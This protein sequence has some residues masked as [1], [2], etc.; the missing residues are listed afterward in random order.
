MKLFLARHG[1][2][3]ADTENPRRP[4]SPRGR[5]MTLQVAAFLRRSGALAAVHSV[6]HSPLPR[7]RE[8]A[9]LLVRELALGA[10]LAA[11]EGLLPEDDPAVIA[12][13]LERTEET[14]L[15]V[16]HEP[17][18]SALATLLVRGKEQPVGF[19]VKKSAVLAL[20]TSGARHRRSRRTRWHLCWHLS[21]ELLRPPDARINP[22]AA[23]IRR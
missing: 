14:V 10:P 3:L 21:P 8:T 7:A 9:E 11:T 13:R 20:E 16:G 18:L 17:H 2:A 22:G 23:G 19:D 6:W 4:L 5:K 12:D 1:H 15:I